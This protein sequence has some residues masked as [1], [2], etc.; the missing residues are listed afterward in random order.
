MK[1]IS[2]GL[3]KLYQTFLS[4]VLGNNCRFYPSCSN[5]AHDAIK[6]HGNL[7]GIWLSFKRIM[8]CH[9]FHKGGIDY[10]PNFERT[11]K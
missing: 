10:V 1:S 3:I 8:K 4:P 11:N 6:S 5:Y 7:K 2:L 9:P